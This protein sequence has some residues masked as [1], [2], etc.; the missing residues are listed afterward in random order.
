[1]AVDYFLK[2]DGIPGESKDDK[3]KGEIEVLSF[4]WSAAQTGTM[5]YGGG[6]GAGKIQMQD[7]TFSMKI[8]RA[9]PKLTEAC[10]DGWHFSKAVLT[11]GK[12]G[13]VQQEFMKYKFTDLLISSC[14]VDSGRGDELPTVQITINYA[15]IEFEYREQKADG[16][17]N[18]PIKGGWNVKANR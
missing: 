11:M 7:F 15:K 5:A 17:L 9:F 2:I 13:K 8:D 12:A 1:M 14:N 16:T 3:H 18:G 10:A 4:S 6:G